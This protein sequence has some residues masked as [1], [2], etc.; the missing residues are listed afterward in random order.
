MNQTTSTP[1]PANRR[2]MSAEEFIKIW[3]GEYEGV[4]GYEEFYRR[5]NFI[6]M[7]S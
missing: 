1:E 3:K 2:K 7:N 6:L 4:E 5:E